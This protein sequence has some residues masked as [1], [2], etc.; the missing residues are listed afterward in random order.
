VLLQDLEMEQR[1][2]RSEVLRRYGN[3]SRAQRKRLRA[4]EK[5]LERIR[6]TFLGGSSKD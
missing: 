1:L 6:R 5:K 4:K 3:M 2:I